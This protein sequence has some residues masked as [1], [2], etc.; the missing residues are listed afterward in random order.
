VSPTPTQAEY[1]VE[2]LLGP[3]AGVAAD[4]PDV[5]EAPSQDLNAGA[6]V[7]RFRLQLLDCPPEKFDAQTLRGLEK[8]LAEQVRGKTVNVKLAELEPL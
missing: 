6:A 3:S 2:Q 5:L 8:I 7:I 4:A 1:A